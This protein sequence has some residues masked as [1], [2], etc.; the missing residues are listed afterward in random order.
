MQVVIKQFSNNVEVQS[1]IAN[2]EW[3][4]EVIAEL[5]K[6]HGKKGQMFRIEAA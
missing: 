3:A 6:V 5:V 2:R 1:V 4:E